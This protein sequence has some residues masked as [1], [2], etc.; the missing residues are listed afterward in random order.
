LRQSLRRT[1]QRRPDLLD[2]AALDARER[3]LVEEMARED[4][5]GSTEREGSAERVGPGSSERE[6]SAERAIQTAARYR[7]NVTDEGPAGERPEEHR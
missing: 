6:G 7:G 3:A 1:L 2:G 5:A 4:G